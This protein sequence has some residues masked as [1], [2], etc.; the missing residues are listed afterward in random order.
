MIRNSYIF[1]PGISTKLE[2]NILES[3][4]G[5]WDDFLRINKIKG[6][7]DKRKKF[8]DF[9]IRKA[10]RNLYCIDSLENDFFYDNMA[11]SEHWRFYEFFCDEIIFLDIEVSHVDGGYITVVSLFDGIESMS[12]VKGINL[13]FF[14][15]NEILSRYKLVVSFNGSVFDRHMLAKFGVKNKM[16]HFDL[17]FACNKIGLKGGLKDIE[18]EVGIKRKNPIVDNLSNGDPYKLW[19]MFNG[20]GDKY[21]LNLLVEYNL[22]DVINLRKLAD[23]CYK[24][25]KRKRKN[26]KI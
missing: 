18:K 2:K 9:L 13:D 5:S 7:S 10:K 1:L 4:V 21:Y 3:G 14:R 20:S 8:L 25:L 6:I 11:L 19:R 22:E 16:L 12:F 15:I 17:R 26:F 23:Y 24:N